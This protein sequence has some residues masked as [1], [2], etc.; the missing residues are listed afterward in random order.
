ML[1]QLEVATPEVDLQMN[2]ILGSNSFRTKKV[3]G[4]SIQDTEN[5][6]APTKVPFVYLQEFIPASHE[7]IATPQVAKQW[8]QL[9]H[10]ADKIPSLVVYVKKSTLGPMQS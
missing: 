6:Y 7:D 1:E 8:K 5:G 10:I 4:L 9:P 2:T 3:T